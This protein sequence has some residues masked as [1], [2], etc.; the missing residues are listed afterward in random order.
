MARIGRDYHCLDIMKGMKRVI[1]LGQFARRRNVISCGGIAAPL[2]TLKVAYFTTRVV[3]KTCEVFELTSVAKH[4]HKALV[5][6]SELSDFN[7]IGAR[8]APLFLQ[9]KLLDLVL[10]PLHFL[11]HEL[12]LSYLCLDLVF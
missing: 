9:V 11:I 2:G 5:V 8:G 4:V 7:H 10:L 12:N 6:F 3:D 1:N